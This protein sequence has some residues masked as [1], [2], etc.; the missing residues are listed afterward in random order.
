MVFANKWLLSGGAK[1]LQL[2]APFFITWFQCLTA[3]IIIRGV[4]LCSS[5]C[6]ERVTFPEIKWCYESSVKVEFKISLK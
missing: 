6:P 5:F 1:N 2:D 4:S 3:V